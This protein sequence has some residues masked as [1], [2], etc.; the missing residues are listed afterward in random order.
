MPCASSSAKIGGSVGGN[1]VRATASISDTRLCENDI[2]MTTPT[3]TGS[4]R[5]V[6]IGLAGASAL[7][8][9]MTQVVSAE[10]DV[11]AGADKAYT[12]MGC[13]GVKHYVNTYPTYHVP[14][15]AGQHEAYLIS[16]LKSYRSGLRK[17]QTCRLM[18]AR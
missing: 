2:M 6:A 10:G 4:L 9:L 1:T 13:H 8:M 5:R 15:I 7:F 17:H 16:A 12:C 11:K 14:K 3:L 18:L